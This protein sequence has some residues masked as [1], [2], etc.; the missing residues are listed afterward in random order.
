MREMRTPQ[1][2]TATAN[3]SALLSTIGSLKEVLKVFTSIT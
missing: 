2:F 3:L 1:G